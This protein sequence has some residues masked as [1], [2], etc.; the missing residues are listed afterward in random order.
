VNAIVQ[1][2]RGYIG[3]RWQHQGRLDD[4]LDCAGLVIKV[5]HDLGLSEFDKTDYPH[6]SSLPEVL[7][8]CREHLDEIARSDLSP[9]DVVVLSC[10]GLP[11][12]GIVGDYLGRDGLL[13]LIH[14]QARHPRQVVEAQFNDI[15]LSYAKASVVGCFRYPEN[16]T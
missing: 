14:S 10:G 9:G 11:H 4:G 13:T 7:G 8:L 16:K 15:Y 1:A 12:L 5:G 2:A 3:T 6:L